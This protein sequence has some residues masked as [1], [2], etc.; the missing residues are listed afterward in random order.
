MKLLGT[1]TELLVSAVAGLLQQRTYALDAF[2]TQRMMPTY[3]E[4][5]FGP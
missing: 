1:P 4:K 2:L 5:L 3:L